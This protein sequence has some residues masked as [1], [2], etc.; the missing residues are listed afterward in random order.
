MLIDMATEDEVKLFLSQFKIKLTIFHIV[1]IDREKNQN[2][3]D[4]EK[5][6]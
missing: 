4:H 1:F 2:V 3:I 6:Y 5:G